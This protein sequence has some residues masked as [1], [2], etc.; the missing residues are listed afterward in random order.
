MQSVFRLQDLS[1]A[2]ANPVPPAPAAAAAKPGTAA[3]TLSVLKAPVKMSFELSSKSA[4]EEENSKMPPLSTTE[5]EA[6]WTI[7][8]GWWFMHLIHISC[9]C[10]NF[11]LG[12]LS[13]FFF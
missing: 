4:R 13:F 6:M 9:H 2:S 1:V 5:E 10:V 11:C 7:G 3:G 12:L 8:T